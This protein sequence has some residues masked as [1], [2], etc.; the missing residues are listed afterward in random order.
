MP[1]RT[2]LLPAI[3]PGRAP[4]LT[5][6]SLFVPPPP[7]PPSLELRNNVQMLLDQKKTSI[8]TQVNLGSD[9]Y[10]QAHVPDTSKIMVS[11]GLGFHAELTLDEAVTL[12]TQREAHYTAAAEELTE[13][14]ARL[15]ARIK[16][17]YGAIDEL[18][19]SS[20]AAAA[21]AAAAGVMGMGR[22]GRG[23]SA[24]GSGS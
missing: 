2:R 5:A 17:V 1:A 15:K 22:A 13:R 10:V 19:R 7:A 21:G 9:F 23:S 6:C 14:A 18:Q 12:C 16:L 11:I 3:L 4:S 20:G 8:K 24:G